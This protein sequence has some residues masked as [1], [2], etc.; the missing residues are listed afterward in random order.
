MDGITFGQLLAANWML[1]T[2]VVVG[3]V[4]LV[5]TLVV[6][7]RRRFRRLPMTI[8]GVRIECRG[9]VLDEDLVVERNWRIILLMT[10]VTRKPA[11]V[12]VLGSR[13]VVKAGRKQYAGTVYLEREARE[14]NPS[15]AIVAW[16]LVRL[17]GGRVPRGV[18]VE[19]TSL[20]RVHAA[21]ST[22]PASVVPVS[23]ASEE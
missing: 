5:V 13:A 2:I 9:A 4:L 21:L 23:P 18:E 6:R 17:G 3:L 19:L 20:M 15:D 12:P 14:L 16:V 10:N 8:N 7:R 11:S 1:L 22:S